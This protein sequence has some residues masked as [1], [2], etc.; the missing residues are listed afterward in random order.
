MEI[1][2]KKNRETTT[3]HRLNG[4]A[5]ILR[6]K[7]KNKKSLNKM[8]VASGRDAS[9]LIVHVYSSLYLRNKLQGENSERYCSLSSR[10]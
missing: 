5:N 7:K 10:C 1:I 4:Y 3:G 8:L 6:M 9:I 2:I